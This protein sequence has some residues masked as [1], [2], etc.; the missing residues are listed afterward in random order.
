MPKKSPA[1]RF[2]PENIHIYPSGREVCANTPAG[3]AEYRRRR[4]IAWKAQ[5]RLHQLYRRL[6]PRKKHQQV[7]VAVAREMV[8]FLWAIDRTLSTPSVA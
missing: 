1:S 6:Q 2:Q 8:G 7:V 5:Q 4:L 3:Y